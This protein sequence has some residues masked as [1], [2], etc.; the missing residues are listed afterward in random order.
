MSAL[1]LAPREKRL[2][3]VMAL[4][5][6]GIV[7]ML[8]WQKSSEALT[9]SEKLLNQAKGHL[10]VAT[11]YRETIISE[12]EG[13]K[14]IQAKLKA[15]SQSFD[16]YNFSN[17]C[18]AE[19]KLQDR[20]SLQSVGLTSRDKAFDGVQITLKHISM[21]ELMDFLLKMYGSNN[22]IMMKKMTYLRPSRDGNG[23]DCSLEMH[24]PKR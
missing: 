20:A 14:I 10:S 23:L 22:L 2:I 24:S 18:I 3:G 15:R 19:G 21:Q 5:M 12:R 7:T 4:V 16:L 13:Q 11:L 17:K 6:V 1:K 9:K 8:L